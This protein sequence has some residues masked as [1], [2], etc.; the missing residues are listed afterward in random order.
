LDI[1]AENEILLDE[2]N[3][4]FGIGKINQEDDMDWLW[5]SP[6]GWDI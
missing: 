4:Q 5:L 3:W 2:G 1:I 6:S